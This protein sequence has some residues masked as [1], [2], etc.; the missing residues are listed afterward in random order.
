MKLGQD[1]L[2][3]LLRR[4]PCVLALHEVL[5][6]LAED[7]VLAA[8]R[9]GQADL[10]DRLKGQLGESAVVLGTAVTL[11]PVLF[12]TAFLAGMPMR[13]F[14][15]LALLLTAPL[16]AQNNANQNQN[17][18]QLRL[19]V[20]DQTGAGIPGADVTLTPKSGGDTMFCDMTAA[21]RD[22]EIAERMIAKAGKGDRLGS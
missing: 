10:A 5:G 17:Q 6:A 22:P 16:Y 7:Q 18:A 9:S 11:I 19:V 8:I 4:G 1:A 14:G 20:V 3:K 13:I 2:G 15:I 12:A 21:C